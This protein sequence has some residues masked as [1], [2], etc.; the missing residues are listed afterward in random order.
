LSKWFE[1]KYFR[2]IDWHE[3]ADVCHPTYYRRL[4]RQPMVSTKMP[5]VLTVYDL[6]HEIFPQETDQTGYKAAEKAEA[7]KRADAIICISENTKSDLIRLYSI[8]ESKVSVIPLAT[9]LCCTSCMAGGLG[10]VPYFLYVG[11][12]SWYKNFTTLLQA[13]AEVSRNNPELRLRIVGSVFTQLE[14]QQAERLGILDK[15]DVTGQIADEQLVEAYSRC[16]AF[17]YPSLYEGF[18]I[19]LLEAMACG[20]PVIAAATS[21]IPEVVGGGALLF[22]PRSVSELS[23]RMRD[24]LGDCSLRASLVAK[25]KQRANE[26]S[27]ERTA[28]ETVEVYRQVIK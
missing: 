18:G 1:P 8:A 28:R 20:A 4:T 21:S 25:G 24:L 7:L 16:L 17:V 13:F 27:W 2:F 12:R 11:G 15:V 9:E 5:V 3:K 26:F 23:A 10:P 6:I 19:P 14:S 22:D